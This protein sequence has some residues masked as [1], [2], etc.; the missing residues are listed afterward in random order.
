MSNSLWPHELSPWIPWI[1]QA[2]ILEW[3]AYPFSRGSS[4]SRNWTRVSCMGGGFFTNWAIREAKNLTL[5]VCF[6]L[7]LKRE[8]KDVWHLQPISS[9]WRPLAFLPWT[10]KPGGLPSMGLHRVWCDLAAATAFLP[11]TLSF[12]PFL[13]GELCCLGKGTSSLNRWGNIF[14]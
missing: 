12:P 5:V 13:L 10:A 3:V 9:I 1:L 7:P 2:R 6:L 14:S 8:R 4:Q 11:V